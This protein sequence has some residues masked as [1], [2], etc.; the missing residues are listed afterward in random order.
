MNSNVRKRALK[1]LNEGYAMKNATLV[2]TTKPHTPPALTG[3]EKTALDDFY[4]RYGVIDKG[5]EEKNQALLKEVQA[6]TF[7]A[8][9]GSE[10]KE[11]ELRANERIYLLQHA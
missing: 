8:F 9:G 7:F 3:N 10:T 2:S 11:M 4:R 5:P 1:R 6:R